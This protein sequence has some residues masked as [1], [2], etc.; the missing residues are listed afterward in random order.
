MKRW[1]KT[2]TEDL[3]AQIT[4][5]E[6]HLYKVSEERKKKLNKYAKN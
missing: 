1:S 5:A 4:Q 2:I 3:I 6:M